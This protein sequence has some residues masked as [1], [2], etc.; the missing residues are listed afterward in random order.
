MKRLT[1]ATILL[2]LLATIGSAAAIHAYATD[3]DAK[4]AP[5][6]VERVVVSEPL[7]TET[8]AAAPVADKPVR[9]A[10][11]PTQRRAVTRYTRYAF[12]SN[13]ALAAQDCREESFDDPVEFDLKYGRGSAA[14]RRCGRFEL[15]RA[16]AECR[17]DAIEDPFDHRSEYGTGRSS[18]TLCVR[19]QLT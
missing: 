10:S 11:T 13:A 3:T 7:Q 18:L 15:A 9:R 8:K 1:P 17:A 12:P 5:A 6:P 16:R 19:D 2:A 4:P 14:I